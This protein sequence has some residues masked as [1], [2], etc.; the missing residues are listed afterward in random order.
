MSIHWLV[1]GKPRCGAP[2]GEPGVE[3]VS[4]FDA[5]VLT[6]TCDECLH[7]FLSEPIA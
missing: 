7:L 6:V 2:E 3:I 1:D 4:P 5:N